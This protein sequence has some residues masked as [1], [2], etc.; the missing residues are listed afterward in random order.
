MIFIGAV[1]AGLFFGF[2]EL[3]PYLSA[4]ATGSI[5]RRGYSGA[6]VRRADDPERFRRL[7]GNRLRGAL[8]GFGIAA[9]A[10]LAWLGL[11]FANVAATVR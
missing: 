3:L 4:K 11:S 5:K 1:L 7:L 10:V 6:V 8:A 9:L 2:R